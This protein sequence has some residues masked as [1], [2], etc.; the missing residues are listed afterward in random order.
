MNTNQRERFEDRLLVA[1]QEIVAERAAAGPSGTDTVAVRPG[2]RKPR[3]AL[4]MVA[5]SLAVAGAL[6]VPLFVGGD[7]AYAVEPQQDGTIHVEIK[8][9]S[10]AEG[11]E[12]KLTE[13]GIPAKVDYLPDGKVCRQPR[14][15]S[16]ETRTSVVS[17]GGGGGTAQQEAGSGS[18]ASFTLRPADFTAGKTLVI[19]T[20]GRR[21]LSSIEVAVVQG[22]VLPCVPVD[23]SDQPPFRP[24]GGNPGG[25]LES[26]EVTTLPMTPPSR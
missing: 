10:D 21:S 26:G 14:Y 12:R 24:E 8:Q 17:G 15:E 5:A 7:S 19:A 25:I 6:V 23:A 9:V 18:S 4:A 20:A 1:L 2:R 16:V 22:P 11:L 3:L 13:L